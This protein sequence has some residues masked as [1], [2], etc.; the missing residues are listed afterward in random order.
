MTPP[1]PHSDLYSIPGYHFVN[2]RKWYTTCEPYSQTQRCRTDIWATQVVRVR[3]EYRWVTGWYFNTLT[4][5]PY[6]TRA[7]WGTNPLANTGEW[8]ASDGRR[9]RTEC[10]TPVSGRNGCRTWVWVSYIASDGFDRSGNRTYA[11]QQ[12]WVVNNLVRFR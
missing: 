1:N 5:L 6:M 8:T 2:G 12:G 4:Y 3:G 10:D 7:Q 9:W 11:W